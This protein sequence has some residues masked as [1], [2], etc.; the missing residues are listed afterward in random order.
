MYDFKYISVCGLY[1]YLL[2]GMMDII[3]KVYKCKKIYKDINIRFI[4]IIYVL[5]LIKYLKGD[6]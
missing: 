2:V 5:N 4:K 1:I 3:Y 6:F